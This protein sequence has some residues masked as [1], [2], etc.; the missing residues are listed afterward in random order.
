MVTQ[1]T[2]C[3]LWF[4]I[5]RE[6]L[7]A[8]H[9]LARCGQCKTV[10]NALATLRHEP[11][12]DHPQPGEAAADEG[13]EEDDPPGISGGNGTKVCSLMPP[14]GLASGGGGGLDLVPAHEP[15]QIGKSTPWVRRVTGGLWSVAAVVAFAAVL[16]QLAY[17]Y[18]WQLVRL[19][20][21]GP[22]V[23]TL[24]RAVGVSMA[25]RL[26]L[27]RYRLSHAELIDAAGYRGGLELT[28][29]LENEMR[30]AQ[31]LPLIAL[32]LTGRRGQ[33]V[34]SR[35]LTP[36]DYGARAHATLPGGS[37]FRVNVKLAD[38]GPSAVGFNLTLC[39]HRGGWIYCEPS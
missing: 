7:R 17:A 5:S 2:V 29:S 28:A 39:K 6:E 34:G 19:P 8:A 12:A 27:A 26:V 32:R 31:A 33:V 30:F 16:L 36:R 11:P 22:I 13:R 4:R 3:R 10:F 20:L 24:Y 35:L 23:A 18:R 37:R 14:V 9:G 21:A 38:P 25:P 1:C 15:A